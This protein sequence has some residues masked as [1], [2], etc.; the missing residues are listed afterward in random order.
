MLT[1][2]TQSGSVHDRVPYDEKTTYRDVVD[3]IKKPVGGVVKLKDHKTT[4]AIFNYTTVGFVDEDGDEVELDNLVDRETVT[5]RTRKISRWETTRTNAKKPSKKSYPYADEITHI[6][7]RGTF[8]CANKVSFQNLVYMNAKMIF[9]TKQNGVKFPD[10][11]RTLKFDCSN[12]Q[13]MLPRGLKN[14]SLNSWGGSTEKL[15]FQEGCHL[16]ELTLACYGE[17]IFTNT[18]YVV[19]VDHLYVKNKYHKLQQFIDPKSIT[20]DQCHDK[21]TWYENLECIT[22]IN[23]TFQSGQSP[24]YFP[25]K[26]R[27]LW[28]YQTNIKSFPQEWPETLEIFCADDFRTDKFNWNFPE[29]CK[30]IYLNMD[31]T[32]TDAAKQKITL[33]PNIFSF[34]CINTSCTIESWGKSKSLE[35]VRI[36][37]DH[38]RI[39]RPLPTTVKHLTYVVKNNYFDSHK[40]ILNHITP[41]AYHLDLGVISDDTYGMNKILI[42]DDVKC[43]SIMPKFIDNIVIPKNMPSN[44]EGV[45]LYDNNGYYHKIITRDCFEEIQTIHQMSFDKII[46]MIMCMFVKIFVNS[47]I[48]TDGRDYLQKQSCLDLGN[49]FEKWKILFDDNE[50]DTGK[51]LEYGDPENYDINYALYP[52]IHDEECEDES[53]SSEDCDSDS[54]SDSDTD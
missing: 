49:R 16:A 38:V 50:L 46:E 42:H 43:F 53:E 10:S 28:L 18:D 19:P 35:Y 1:I 23:N 3:A 4:D 24:S 45:V 52:E 36:Q 6:T 29:R 21:I 41:R 2:R 47:G 33:P 14:L 37:G 9:T 31:I 25:P 5:I 54:E 40:N 51:I 39:D 17:I 22:I 20:I 30:Q 15:H 34:E 27:E 26:L 13:M 12:D 32:D 11:L 7:C 48:A 8:T 44:L